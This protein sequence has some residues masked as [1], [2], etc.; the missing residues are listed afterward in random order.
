MRKKKGKGIYILPNLLTS[1]SLLSGFYSII[2]TIDRKFIYASI[3][4]FISGIFDMLD[5][6]VARMTGSSSRFGVEY[7]SL[8]D[9]VAFGVAPGLLVYIW[10]LKGYGR[11]GWLAAFLYVACGALRLARFNIQVDNVQKKHFLGLPI[12]AAAII[13]A[14]SVLF[15]SWLGYK[16]E[17]KTIVMP[18]L[19][20]ILAFL[21]VSDVRYYSFKDMA[22]FKGKPFR[23]TLAVILLLVI[24]FIE[25]KVTLFVLATMYLLSGPVFTLINSLINRKKSIPGEYPRLKEDPSERDGHL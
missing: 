18:I 11:F 16:S 7:D 21:M 19:V 9:L 4:I 12:P 22:F 13:I 8:C 2:S 20:Y 14:G 15:Y 6:R 1:I 25:P 10:A 5:G 24:I 3:A 23:S 17:L